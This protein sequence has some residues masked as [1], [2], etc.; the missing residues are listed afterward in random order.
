MELMQASGERGEDDAFKSCNLPE[1]MRR[2]CFN[3]HETF[4]NIV[5]HMAQFR[6]CT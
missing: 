2:H 5:I 6:L 3:G 4:S 1:F